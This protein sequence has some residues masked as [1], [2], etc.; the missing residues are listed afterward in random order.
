MGSRPLSQYEIEEAKRVFREGL[1]YKPIKIRERIKFALTVAK[2]WS[3]IMGRPD[4]ETNAMTIGNT[5]VVSRRLRTQNTDPEESRLTDIA[6]LIHELTHVW[7]FQRYKWKY[8]TQA[9]GAQAKR[10]TNPYVYSTAATLEGKGENLRRMW[11]IDGKRFDSFNH[12]QQGDI[13]RDFYRARKADL[14][15]TGWELFLGEIRSYS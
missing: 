10:G 1:V 13:A 12:E 6:W 9:I 3:K 5:I 14:D 8:L 2:V 15:T 4:P 7:Q 11:E